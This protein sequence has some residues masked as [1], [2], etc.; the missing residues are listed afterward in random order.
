[1]TLD[2]KMYIKS[3]VDGA[4]A[5]EAQPTLRKVVV[6]LV[7]FSDADMRTVESSS[8]SNCDEILQELINHVDKPELNTQELLG[9][10]FLVFLHRTQLQNA[11]YQAQLDQ[12]KNSYDAV[13]QTVIR[14]RQE[15]WDNQAE[16]SQTREDHARLHKDDSILH[17]ETQ[18]DQPRAEDQG[19]SVADAPGQETRDATP[20]LRTGP[21]LGTAK[22]NLLTGNQTAQLASELH[23]PQGS[24]TCFKRAPVPTRREISQPLNHN[25]LGDSE[26]SNHSKSPW[27][28]QQILHN[29]QLK[30]LARDIEQ[31]DPDSKDAHIDDYLRGVKR[32]PIDLPHAS[33]R[34]KFKLIW[35]TTAKSVHA[36]IGTLQPNVQISNLSLKGN[37][38]PRVKLN[39]R[40]DRQ[41][42]RPPRHK[43]NSTDERGVITLT[44]RSC[45]HPGQKEQP[46]A[47]KA[48]DSLHAHGME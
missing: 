19:K 1:M 23:A 11:A 15:A 3:Y 44:L 32:C 31:F 13:L 18:A 12:I 29:R 46:P 20:D 26:I 6:D 16:I 37:K 8:V 25:N 27:S 48:R 28:H 39:G 9:L 21:L 22:Q 38:G 33:A 35:K 5:P 14:L 7:R 36:F 43:R 17:A 24:H 47:L 45:T 30:S 2:S 4:M 10:M 40:T 41:R 34:E 42:R